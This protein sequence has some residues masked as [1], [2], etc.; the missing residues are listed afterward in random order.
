MPQSA[1]GKAIHYLLEQWPNLIAYLEEGSLEISNNRTER[2]IK[3][4]VIDRKD[5]LFAITSGDE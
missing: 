1:F 5:F 3:P 2:S 4:F